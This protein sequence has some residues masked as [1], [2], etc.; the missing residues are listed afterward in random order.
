MG[1]PGETNHSLSQADLAQALVLVVVMAGRGFGG[2]VEDQLVAEG[3]VVGSQS[4]AEDGKEGQLCGNDPGSHER[5]TGRF[6]KRRRSEAGA[7][8]IASRSRACGA[9]RGSRR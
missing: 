6:R 2:V 4:G 8:V 1:I 9:S 5:Q 3:I 7:L